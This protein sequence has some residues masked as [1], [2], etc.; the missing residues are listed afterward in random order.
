MGA[1]SG[2]ALPAVLS[3]PQIL[4]LTSEILY[5]VAEMSNRII[6]VFMRLH[7]VTAIL[8]GYYKR[9]SSGMSWFVGQ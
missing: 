9:I 7:K 1:A 6:V 8:D 3:W 4:E 2:L 5:Q